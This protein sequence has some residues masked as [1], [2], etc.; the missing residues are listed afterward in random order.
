MQG[1]HRLTIL[2]SGARV[3]VRMA[4]ASDGPRL[5]ELLE[6][7]GLHADDLELARAV[8]FDPREHTTLVAASLVDRSEELVGLALMDRRMMTPELVVGDEQ[9]APGVVRTL[10]DAVRGRRAA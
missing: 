3:R 10:E 9:H 8:R 1:L 2:D 7:L 6:R 5:R 4:H